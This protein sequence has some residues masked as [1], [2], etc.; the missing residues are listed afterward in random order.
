MDM[1]KQINMHFVK[2]VILYDWSLS[3]LLV[4]CIIFL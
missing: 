2:N 3:V 1:K 4:A